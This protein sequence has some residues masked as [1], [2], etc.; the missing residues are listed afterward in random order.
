MGADPIGAPL[1][2]QGNVERAKNYEPRPPF[3]RPS[4]ELAI[5]LFIPPLRI[6]AAELEWASGVMVQK[7]ASYLLRMQMRISEPERQHPSWRRG[8]IRTCESCW[9]G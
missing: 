3:E 9:L 7:S 4:R 1:A 2:G 5:S 8:E 6:A